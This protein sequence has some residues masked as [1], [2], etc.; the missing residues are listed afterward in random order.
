MKLKTNYYKTLLLN[1]E[2]W[3]KIL[4]YSKSNRSAIS[5]AVKEL[6][7]WLEKHNINH[8]SE[9][10][11]KHIE[12]Y[13]IHLSTRQN[14]RKTGA[15]S[16]G[17]LDKHQ[18][19]I[20]KFREYLQKNEGFNFQV[21]LNAEKLEERIINILT[22][23]E[24]K[25]LFDTT[26]LMQEPIEILQR[27]RA[28]LV[29]LYSCGLRRNEASKLNVSDILFESRRILV[30]EG[31]NYKERLVPINLFNL[32]LLKTYLYD[33]RF[34]HQR[35]TEEEAFLLSYRGKRLQGQSFS[36]RLKRIQSYASKSLQEK[37]ISPHILRH[38]IATHLLNRK[39]NIE[40]ISRFLGHSSLESTQI[41]TH[42][43][44]DE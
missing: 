23:Q 14:K 39:V 13:Y 27:D 5:E 25:E 18:Y 33:G 34:K 38:S 7:E 28:M 35:N 30:R 19:A 21:V 42:I 2:D 16:A 1:F 12:S 15:L 4:G 24:I 22:E 3:I 44:Q 31:K 6:L 40:M 32:N 17:S 41:Y 11:K 20:R 36:H 29:I 43:L 8:C 10:T 26:F 37:H 9:I